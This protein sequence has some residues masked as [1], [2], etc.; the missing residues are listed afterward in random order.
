MSF[1]IGGLF[2]DN[3]IHLPAN[4]PVYHKGGGNR[5]K[6]FFT[7][8]P[9]VHMLKSLRKTPMPEFLPI[10]G[11]AQRAACSLVCIDESIMFKWERDLTQKY[12]CLKYKSNF[13]PKTV[14]NLNIFQYPIYE[15]KCVEPFISTGIDLTFFFLTYLVLE[16][17]N[18]N[19]RVCI[20]NK[21]VSRV[22]SCPSKF[23]QCYLSI[24]TFSTLKVKME[25]C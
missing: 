24:N 25:A 23:C 15:L 18:A 11:L 3:K 7:E 4:V 20:E 8:P 2:L 6:C 5:E 1:Q 9:F 19:E 17:D 13:K 14:K 10:V 16:K 12:Y 22:L 21:F